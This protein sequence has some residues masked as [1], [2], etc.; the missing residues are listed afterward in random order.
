MQKEIGMLWKGYE[1]K[2]RQGS[3]CSISM[4]QDKGCCND[5]CWVHKTGR[6]CLISLPYPHTGR[7]HYTDELLG[8]H[9][10]TTWKIACVLLKSN[11]SESPLSMRL[12]PCAA[13]LSAHPDLQLAT[14]NMQSANE[15]TSVVDEY[16]KGKM[17]GGRILGPFPQES[18]PAIQINR[19]GFIPKGHTPGKWQLIMNLSF[20]EG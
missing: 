10:A 8:L 2:R 9:R 4:Y 16:L 12:S 11:E 20:S 15:H 7:Y 5:V 3:V 14:R 13:H 1:G 17:Q 6:Y 18:V 19:L